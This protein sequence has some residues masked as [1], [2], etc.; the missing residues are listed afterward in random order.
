MK[1]QPFSKVRERFQVLFSNR[2]D[3]FI[4]HLHHQAE[5]GLQGAEALINYMDKPSKK[6]ATQVKS[7]EKQADE[8]RRI[9]IDELNRTFITPIDRED[10]YVLSRT[11][12]DIIDNTY[13]TI[14]EMDILS[15]EPNEYLIEMAQMLHESTEEILLAIERL[16]HHPNVADTHTVRVRAIENRM[17]EYYLQALATLFEKPDSLKEVTQMLKL[18]EIYRHMF[19]AVQSTEQA[20]NTISDIVVKFY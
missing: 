1:I 9:L 2:G 10:L 6:N 4:K 14:S 12:D 11:L 3:R 17:E 7:I 18:R 13:S 19:Q 15:V 20:A 5:L 16:E 8:V